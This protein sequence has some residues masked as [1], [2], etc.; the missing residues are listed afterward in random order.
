MKMFKIICEREEN[1]RKIIVIQYPLDW[2]TAEFLRFVY[3]TK[4]YNCTIE[5]YEQDG[6]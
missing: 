4:Y 2:K 6:I 5:E 1:G 3:H